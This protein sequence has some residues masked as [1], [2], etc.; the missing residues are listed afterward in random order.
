M[1]PHFCVNPLPSIGYISRRKNQ[2]WLDGNIRTLFLQD[3]GLYVAPE[4]PAT[5]LTED[6]YDEMFR[7]CED[8]HGIIC[9]IRKNLRG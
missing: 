1:A 9:V 5:T 2:F 8:F 4:L 6:C 3:V 7:D